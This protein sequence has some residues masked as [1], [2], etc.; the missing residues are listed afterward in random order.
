MRFSK[1]TCWTLIREKISLEQLKVKVN[2]FQLSQPILLPWCNG[3]QKVTIYPKRK[4]NGLLSTRLCVVF[5]CCQKKQQFA[6][7]EPHSDIIKDIRYLN[8]LQACLGNLW[9]NKRINKQP[10]YY[11]AAWD[12]FMPDNRAVYCHQSHDMIRIL[13][14]VVTVWDFHGMII[15]SENITVSRYTVLNNQNRFFLV[16]QMFGS[17]FIQISLIKNNQVNFIIDYILV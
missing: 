16:E 14:R 12:F 5:G 4:I 3:F 10:I 13:I 1:A 6:L 2:M 9:K 7:N 15:V 8:T 17:M 11:R